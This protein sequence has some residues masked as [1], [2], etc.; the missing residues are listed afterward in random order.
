MTGKKQ[1][2]ALTIAT[3]L[4]NPV[5]AGFVEEFVQATQAQ[6]NVTRAGVLEGAAR[7]VVTGG[8]FVYKTP[9]NEFVPVSVTPPSLKAGCGGI[10]VF[11]GAFSI[12][13]RDEFVSFLRSV[14]TALPGLAFQLAL[15]TMAPDLNEMVGRYA[16][17]I[18]SYTNRYTDACQAA[19]ALF[20]STGARAHMQEALLQAKNALRSSGAVADQSEADKTVRAHGGKAIEHAPT[21]KDDAGNIISA[22]EINLT[23][24]IVKSGK[25]SARAISATEMR[26]LMM[27][28]VGTTIFRQSGS[29][30]DAVL[31]AH[32]IAGVDLL[33]MLFGEIDSGTALKLK[34]PDTR[35]CLAPVTEPLRDINLVERMQEAA[36]NY[37][38][39][40]E[41]RN[42]EAVSN[43]DLMLLAASSGV[44][45]LRILNLVSLT[46]WTGFGE[47]LVRVYV[48]AAAFEVLAAAVHALARD[49]RTVLES[50]SVASYSEQHVAHVERL[51]AR[52]GEIER[53]VHARQ[54]RVMQA[55]MRAAALVRQLE[56][57]EQSLIA[58]SA[59]DLQAV[60]RP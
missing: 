45:L 22:A 6:V 54:D 40:L 47:D 20:E 13:S 3:A 33:P 15:Q 49:V 36:H 42:A 46:Q 18:R 21:H 50:S 41:K 38:R 57:I 4:A 39:A 2:I 35:L 34:C 53:A 17:L 24:A 60:M 23:W 12:P 25:W 51:Q 52:L 5:Q 8:G 37:L 58:R 56:H 27:T 7:H 44:P 11:L 30:E 14:G 28:L 26:E 19:E 29:G 10:D 43:D 55:M 31:T 59:Q 1:L 16:D 32:S 48:E 9:R